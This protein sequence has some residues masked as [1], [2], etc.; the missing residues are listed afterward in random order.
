MQPKKLKIGLMHISAYES[1]WT[2]PFDLWY[3]QMLRQIEFADTAG[4]H[5]VWVAEHRIPGYGFASPPVFLTAAAARTRRIRLGTAVCL[6]S[7]HHPVQTAEDYAALD[8]LSGGRLNFGVGRGQFPYDFAVT[9]IDV[10]EGRAR[11]GE[12]LQAILSLWSAEVAAHHGRFHQFT[13]RLLPKPLQRP[14]PPVY[15]A[16][17][18]TPASYTWAGERGFHLQIVPFIFSDLAVLHEYIQGYRHAA[19]A[20]GHDS[21]ALDLAAAY[22]LYVGE[23]EEDALQAADPHLQRLTRYNAWALYSGL[24]CGRPGAFEHYLHARSSGTSDPVLSPDGGDPRDWQT[25]KR[26]RVIFGTPDQVVDQIGRVAEDHGVTYLMFE[27]YYGGQS[28]REVMGYL[29][30][31]AARVMPQLDLAPPPPICQPPSL[32]TDAVVRR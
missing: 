28:H 19:A 9:G 16:A 31:L 11:F 4:L 13:H 20:N 2:E 18:R 26:G 7:L 21:T 15:A 3:E 10:D 5:G 32:D 27:V 12:N 29:E 6:V 22:P 8:V 24:D 25:W 23:R 14:H 17:A 30:R 1:G